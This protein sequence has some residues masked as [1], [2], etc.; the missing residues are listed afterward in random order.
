MGRRKGGIPIPKATGGS[1]IP[2]PD[3]AQRR[4]TQHE[5]AVFSFEIFDASLEC[6]SLWQGDEV[7]LLVSTF[8]KVSSMTWDQIVKTGGKSKGGKK[9]GLGY[10]VFS[11]EESPIA[12]PSSISPDLPISE[13]RV[14]LKARIFGARKDEKYF[15]ICLDRNHRLC[16]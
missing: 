3:P 10:T 16:P 2:A 8:K 7:K 15:V 11:D 14:T 6:P 1:N 5:K 9:K 13:M 4:S 12:R